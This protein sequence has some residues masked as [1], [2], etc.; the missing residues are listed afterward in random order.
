EGA[1]STTSLSAKP[2]P[3]TRLPFLLKL[4]QAVELGLINSRE[5][6]DFRENLYMVA[7]PVT[8]QRFAFSA[9]FFAFEQYVRRWAGSQAQGGHRNDSTFS[10]NVGVAKLFSTGALMLFNFANQTVFNLTGMGRSVTSQSAINFDL[11]Q[12]LLRGGGRAVTLEP[13]TQAE[14]NLLY[15]IREFA[16]FPNTFYLAIASAGGGGGRLRGVAFQ[17]TGVLAAPVFS[18][19]TGLGSAG[20]TPGVFATPNVT[21]NPGL[22]ARV[23]TAGQIGLQV[24]LAAPVSGYLTTLLQAAQMKVD[25]YSIEKLEDYLKLAKAL[26][27]GGDISGLQVDQFEQ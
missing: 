26:E 19:A 12:P 6:Q 15:E 10:S 8:L 5:Y 9:Q 7:L 3:G 1:S 4:E 20:L 18:P 11:I 23:G 25:E 13:L 14:R 16:R 21:G 27:E 24:A 2:K 22:Q 17:P